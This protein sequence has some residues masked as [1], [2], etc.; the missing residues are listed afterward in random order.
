MPPLRGLLRSGLAVDFLDGLTSLDMIRLVL[1]MVYDVGRVDGVIGARRLLMR[2]RRLWYPLMT[3][4]HRFFGA[5][6]RCG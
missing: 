4:V 3:K 6:S 5:V 1:R 2:A